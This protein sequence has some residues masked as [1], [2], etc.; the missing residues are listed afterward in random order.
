MTTILE[1]IGSYTIAPVHFVA[2]IGEEIY[3]N[4]IWAGH[5]IKL[6]C[7]ENK[8]EIGRVFEK[9]LANLSSLLVLQL[10]SIETRMITYGIAMVAT[11]AIV[12][13]DIDIISFRVFRPFALSASLDL[14]HLGM[15][16][17]KALPFPA[18]LIVGGYYAGYSLPLAFIAANAEHI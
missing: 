9:F 15:F 6:L 8:A 2:E 1:T 11:L 12:A 4:I 7:I 18:D 14:A 17:Y 3:D 13:F 10:L 5:N 16:L